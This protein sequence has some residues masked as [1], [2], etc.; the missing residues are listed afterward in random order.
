MCTINAQPLEETTSPTPST[1][2]SLSFQMVITGVVTCA[3]LLMGTHAASQI[4]SPSRRVWIPNSSPTFKVVLTH[5][6]S[7]KANITISTTDRV[8]LAGAALDTAISRL[9]ADGLFDGTRANLTSKGH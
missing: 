4:A 3:L 1:R 7:Q 8:S 9:D 2:F 6:C 5:L